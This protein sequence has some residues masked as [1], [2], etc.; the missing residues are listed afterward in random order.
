[1]IGCADRP[2]V[3]RYAVALLPAVSDAVAHVVAV[4]RHGHSRNGVTNLFSAVP[5]HHH[6]NVICIQRQIN[7]IRYMFFIRKENK[8]AVPPETVFFSTAH[9][10]AAL[11]GETPG[12]FPAIGG[13]IYMFSP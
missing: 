8:K 13:V 4:R 10:E 3:V 6:Q 7:Y 9:P 2:R 5:L 11:Q 12:K 1:M